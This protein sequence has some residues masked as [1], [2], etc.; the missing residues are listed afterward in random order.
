[1]NADIPGAGQPSEPGLDVLLRLL[2]AEPT[3]DELADEAAAVRMF[4][5]NTVQPDTAEL[6]PVPGPHTAELEPV[7]GPVQL[8]PRARRRRLLAGVAAAAAVA[9]LAVATYAGALP[10][11]LQNAA[12][13]A[14]RFAGVPDAPKSVPAVSP[15]ATPAPGR[16]AP[17]PGGARTPAASASPPAGASPV[18]PATTSTLSIVTRERI[19]AG[20]GD[21]F[22]GRLANHGQAVAGATVT[23]LER[24][25]GQSAWEP[26]GTA[27][28]GKDGVAAVSVSGLT[29]NAG[30]Q[31]A[32]PNGARSAQVSV[33]VVPPVTASITRAPRGQPDTLTA[34]SPLADPGDS[35]VLQTLTSNGWVSVQ[36]GPLD[37][38]DQVEFA[39]RL[40][41]GHLYRVALLPTARH[42][43][44]VSN[45]A[46]VP[47]R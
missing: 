1:V 3:P 24:P 47:A 10:A 27:T 15:G 42:G 11:S 16:G 23:L 25:A 7:P 17:P 13:H 44:S 26:A 20:A 2:T 5:A 41:A 33:V 14:L 28:T 4:L 9:A 34:S 32:G 12:S 29:T 22:L 30:F 19:V 38:S 45:T 35:V 18:A 36:A 46:A 6:E 8:R 31:L 37:T 43:L 21:T 39:V 40:P